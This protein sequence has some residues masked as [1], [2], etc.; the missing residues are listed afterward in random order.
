MSPTVP[1]G[2][3]PEVI[4]LTV[5][6]RNGLSSIYSATSQAAFDKAFSDFFHNDA[7]ITV[8]GKHL[9][10]AQYKQQLQGEKFL[11]Q[12]SQV[13][14]LNSVEVTTGRVGL[15]ETGSVGIYYKVQLYERLLFMGAPVE[16]ILNSSLNAQVTAEGNVVKVSALDEVA[17]DQVPR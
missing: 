5:F 3:G 9:T 2:P 16:S 12:S 8:N 1:L 10:L 4:S 6:V 7:K 11:E 15:I 14:I 13:S 17:F